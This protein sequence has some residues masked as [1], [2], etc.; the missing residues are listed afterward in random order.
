M[1]M[2]MV[3]EEAISRCTITVHLNF[4]SP[5][6]LHFCELKNTHST[7]VNVKFFSC[8]I[9]NVM[10][11]TRVSW[12]YAKNKFSHIHSRESETA[13]FRRWGKL[14]F[15]FAYFC[16]LNIACEIEILCKI[17][18]KWTVLCVLL[19]AATE[20][21]FIHHKLQVNCHSRQSVQ[22]YLCEI[23]VTTTMKRDKLFMT[24]NNKNN[25]NNFKHSVV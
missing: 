18:C 22:Y 13:K 12:V 2:M 20:G 3:K 24:L 7:F 17:L 11:V 14:L 21:E 19:F 8:N 25:K 5:L 23:S 16:Q 9:T 15:S 10:Y 4:F 1:M 6:T